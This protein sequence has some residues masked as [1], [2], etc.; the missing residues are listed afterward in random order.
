MRQHMMVFVTGKNVILK[1]YLCECDLCQRF[2]SG[3][4][5]NKGSEADLKVHECRF[6]N[7]PICSCSYK[8]DT[9]KNSHS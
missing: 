5:A 4:C 3:K 7:L 1:E 8:D 2:E 9:L 6:E